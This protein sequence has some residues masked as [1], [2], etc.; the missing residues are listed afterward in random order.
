MQAY[1]L[2]SVILV[3]IFAILFILSADAVSQE[4]TTEPNSDSDDDETILQ[5]P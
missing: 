2:K 5:G 4:I 1:K 3:S